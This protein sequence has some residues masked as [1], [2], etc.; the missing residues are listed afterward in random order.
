SVPQ[1]CGYS[2]IG[3]LFVSSEGQILPISGTLVSF[4]SETV[5]LF[6][7]AEGFVAPVVGALA[8]AP[9]HK[10][11]WKTYNFEVERYHTYVAGGLRVHNASVSV[12]AI[13][14]ALSGNGVA[15]RI[16]T[17]VWNA[18]QTNPY[19]TIQDRA[20]GPDRVVF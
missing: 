2:C 20:F 6:E 3:C 18:V 19:D 9:V 11:G 17:E 16:G 15:G 4:D 10:S 13:S 5:G 1:C 7:G 8:E 14:D 12:G